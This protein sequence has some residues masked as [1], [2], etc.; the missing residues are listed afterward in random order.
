MNHKLGIKFGPFLVHFRAGSTNFRTVRSLVLSF[1]GKIIGP[2]RRQWCWWI[3]IDKNYGRKVCCWRRKK[4]DVVNQT[5]TNIWK[6]S[7]TSIEPAEIYFWTIKQML[8]YLNCWNW[9]E[10]F[11]NRMPKM[12]S[13]LYPIILRSLPWSISYTC[14]TCSLSKQWNSKYY[15]FLRLWLN[16]EKFQ[17]SH[18]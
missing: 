2:K 6:L 11:Q 13:K 15:S 5:G 4:I 17:D 10:M 1:S 8:D 14:I 7:P 18:I 9:A 3:E 16:S 12:H